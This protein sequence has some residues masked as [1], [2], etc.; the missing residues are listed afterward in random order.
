M[1]MYISQTVGK[2]AYTLHL[3]CHWCLA[4]QMFFNPR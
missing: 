1:Y 4:A 2:T 3:K